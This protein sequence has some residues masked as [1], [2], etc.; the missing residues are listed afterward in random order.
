M[1]GAKT[2]GGDP[3]SVFEAGLGAGSRGDDP[4]SCPHD[5]MTLEFGEWQRGHRLGVDLLRETEVGYAEG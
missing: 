5:K 3:L 1:D 2:S 4:R